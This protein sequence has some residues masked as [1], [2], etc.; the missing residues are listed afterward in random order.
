M[1]ILMVGWEYPPKN[2]GGLGVACR[3]IVEHLVDAGQD[4]LLV[5]PKE[6]AVETG[7]AMFPTPR[8]RYYP[9]VFVRSGL[10]PYSRPGDETGN[11][12][13]LIENVNIFAQDVVKAVKNEK[14]DLVHVHDW[15]TV[16][17]GIALRR[18]FGKPLIMH[19]HS[20]EFD[21]TG[22]G[23]PNGDVELIEQAGFNEADIVV[24]VSGYTG[25]LLMARYG[26]VPEKLRVVHNGIDMDEGTEGETDF[27]G[28]VPVIIF[29]GRLTVQKGPEFFIGLAEKVLLVRPEA[30]FIIVGD[31]DMYRKMIEHAA[32]R[33]LTGSVLFTGFLRGMNK[34]KIFGRADVFV[35]PSV[36]EPF[37]LVALE[38]AVAGVPVIISKTSGVAEVLPSAI[39][40]DYWDTDLTAQYVLDL[41]S[42]KEKSEVVGDSLK[43][44]AGLVS[45]DK[46]ALEL[47]TIYHQLVQHA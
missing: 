30:I 3:G 1:R 13:G 15:L 23:E 11:G 27:L 45:W 44:E 9:V 42:D 10:T 17:A 34:S 24:A 43:M 26:V 2:S 47:Q 21:R 46:A 32:F 33:E 19:V 6:M 20:T 12:K 14:F 18:M 38:A 29:V 7:M 41:I 40:V 16:P 39:Q 37:G 5:L 36:S 31:G 25:N 22:G 35:M 8:G 4:I 28:N